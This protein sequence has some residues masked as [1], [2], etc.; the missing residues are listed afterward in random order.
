MNP[1]TRALAVIVHDHAET[2]SA[3]TLKRASTIAEMRSELMVEGEHDG[4]GRGTFFALVAWQI[5]C[6]IAEAESPCECDVRNSPRGRRKH[7]TLK[8]DQHDRPS[9][10]EVFEPGLSLQ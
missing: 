3:I 5:R 10:R 8:S 4:H 6:A 2:P 9:M 1:F 7:L